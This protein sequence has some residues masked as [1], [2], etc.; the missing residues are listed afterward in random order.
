MKSCGNA[1]ARYPPATDP[2][3]LDSDAVSVLVFG[4]G[5]G[6]S[7]GCNMMTIGCAAASAIDTATGRRMM[8]LVALALGAAALAGCSQSSGV[9]QKSELRQSR[10]ASLE[11]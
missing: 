1:R 2:P 10:E 9:S 7:W 5:W 4:L 11:G 8:R 3:R 6:A